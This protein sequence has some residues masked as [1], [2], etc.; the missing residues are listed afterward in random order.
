MENNH[1]NTITS[2]QAVTF[3]L[4]IQIGIG[5]LSLPT[6]MARVSGHDGWISTLLGGIIVWV[7]ALIIIMLCGRF[8]GSSIFDISRIVFGKYFGFIL[9]LLL[10]LYLIAASVVNLRY[11][12]IWIDA[13]F[14]RDT[15]M[16]ILTLLLIIPSAYLVYKGLKGICRFNNIVY[17]VITMI[18]ILL[19]WP[20]SQIFRLTQLMPVSDAGI[21][22]ILKGVPKTA[23]SYMG[24]ET[25][26]FIY[27]FIKNKRYLTKNMSIGL[28][29]TTLLYTFATIVCLGVFGENML[30][31]RTQPIIGLARLIKFPIFERIDIYFLTVGIP[32]MALAVHSY[33]FCTLNA[34]NEVFRVNRNN[35]LLP[36][37]LII[38]IL[39]SG[40]TS[41]INDLMN[42]A[43]LVG[44]ISF[45]FGSILPVL[46]LVAAVIFR[47][48]ER[49]KR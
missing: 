18:I 49:C 48:G 15:P 3:I 2:K 8:K 33:I 11:Y 30:K 29:V 1:A 26:L 31:N 20:L 14:F 13:W 41:D 4:G 16:W 21:I 47:K 6:E 17:F 36:V 22:R 12:T 28:W 27:P 10:V 7:S 25:L 37:L 24:F 23:F 35:V 19:I 45:I 9:N 46:Y 44:Q 5:N 38:V 40:F 39:L 32:A 34:I 43:S 42:A